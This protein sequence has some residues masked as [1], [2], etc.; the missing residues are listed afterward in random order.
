MGSIGVKF[1]EG[2]RRKFDSKWGSPYIILQVKYDS[3]EEAI[4]LAAGLAALPS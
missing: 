1:F 2:A 4:S 3:F